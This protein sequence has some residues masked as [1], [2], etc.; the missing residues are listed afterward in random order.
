MADSIN[1]SGA[2]FTLT[3]ERAADA[4]VAVKALAAS[5][6]EQDTFIAGE[7]AEQIGKVP[8]LTEALELWDWET[9]TN[10]R[11]DIVGMEFLAADDSDA[12]ELLYEALAPYAEP[13][14]RLE[15]RDDF[16]NHWRW[17][18]DGSG[19]RREVGRIAY[20][21]EPEPLTEEQARSLARHVISAAV[22]W[23]E[24][25]AH[26]D[27]AGPYGEGESAEEDRISAV[28]GRAEVLLTRAL[29]G[30][31]STLDRQ[32]LEHL[33]DGRCEYAESYYG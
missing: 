27:W 12:Y 10:E 20:G 1:F 31:L 4:L 33:L 11:G 17:V 15:F 29:A 3:R 32:D 5:E 2:A 14:S 22:R 25:P 28:L 9:E 23:A 26:P 13:S 21:A 7:I 24:G 19:V 6:K 8:T 18:F 16:G 30:K